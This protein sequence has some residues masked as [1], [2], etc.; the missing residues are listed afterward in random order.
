MSNSYLDSIVDLLTIN[1]EL[2][3]SLGLHSSQNFIT[4]WLPKIIL[5]LNAVFSLNYM[6]S[7]KFIY[8][9]LAAKEYD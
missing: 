2:K 1:G 3:S 8:F 4:L 6:A 7:C 9:R 5:C